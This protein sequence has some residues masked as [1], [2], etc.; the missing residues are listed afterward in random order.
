MSKVLVATYGSLRLRM[1][2]ARVNDRA[3]GKYLASGSTVNNYDLFRYGGGYFP[4]VSLVHS[5]SKKPVV[6][7]VYE[8]TEEGLTGAYD[9]LEGH[10]GND[11]PHTFYKRT[12][13]P[14]RLDSGE[15]VMAWIY[16]I[17][18]QQETR[19]PSGDWCTYKRPYYYDEV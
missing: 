6:V 5:E 2:N 9:M 1:E 18:E 10:R 8:T 7:D 13:I 14:V 19:V 16:H 3:G 17:D 15:E 4:S 12:Q 11:N